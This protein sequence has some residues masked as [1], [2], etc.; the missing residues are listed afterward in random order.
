MIA[1]AAGAA[2]LEWMLENKV[3]ERALEL[4]KKA[5]VKL[6]VIEKESSIVGESRGLGLMLAIEMVKDKKT[7]EPAEAYAKMVRKYAHQRGVMIEVGGHHNFLQFALL[8]Y[9]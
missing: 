2:G 7:K 4:G 5:M 6:K 8:M 3:A 1:F 9:R